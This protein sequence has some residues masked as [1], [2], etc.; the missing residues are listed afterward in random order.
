MSSS[1]GA[2]LAAISATRGWGGGPS[3]SSGARPGDDQPPYAGWPIQRE[4]L[5]DI[6]AKRP[7]QQIDGLDVQRV[8]QRR[9]DLGHAVHGA[10]RNS[11][12]FADAHAVEPDHPPLPRQQLDEFGI[13]ILHR[14]REIFDRAAGV[15]P[16]DRRRCGPRRRQTAVVTGAERLLIV[17]LMSGSPGSCSR[18]GTTYRPVKSGASGVRR[19]TRRNVGKTSPSTVTGS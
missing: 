2:T 7:A 6:T 19:T 18:A 5:R 14:C 8:K 13:P 9:H 3:G 16:P 17:H 1:V 10:G 12:S 4:R 11:A 15:I